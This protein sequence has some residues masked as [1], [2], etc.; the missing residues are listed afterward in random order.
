MALSMI[1]R[2]TILSGHITYVDEDSFGCLLEELPPPVGVLA[3]RLD[4]GLLG[5]VAALVCT[6]VQG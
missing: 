4:E 6:V 5:M 3:S 2:F 1:L